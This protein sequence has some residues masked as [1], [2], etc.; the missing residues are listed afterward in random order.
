MKKTILMIMFVMLAV[1]TVSGQDYN[2]QYYD[3][4]SDQGYGYNSTDIYQEYSYDYKNILSQIGRYETVYYWEH[5]YKYVNFVIVGRK[6]YIIPRGKFYEIYDRNFFQLVSQD[7]FISLSCFG[8]PYYDNYYRFSLYSDY[9][10]YNYYMGRSFGSYW[11]R[12]LRRHYRRYYKSRKTHKRYKKYKI[13]FY[14][15]RGHRGD[16]RKK[17]IPTKSQSN[18]TV[19]K[20]QKRKI[21]QKRSPVYKRSRRAVKFTKRY[22]KRSIK[23]KVKIVKSSRSIKKSNSKRSRKVRKTSKNK[24]V[25]KR[26]SKR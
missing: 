19:R 24:K 14:K 20:V 6:V 16:Y 26:R 7:R 2:N 5:P 11:F 21:A 12:G 22:V 13:R 15:K 23:K 8:M 1:L 4:Y 3:Q 18:Y 9:F 25:S 17:H 10:R